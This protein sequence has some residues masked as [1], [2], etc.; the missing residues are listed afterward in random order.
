MYGIRIGIPVLPPYFVTPLDGVKMHW[1]PESLNSRISGKQSVTEGKRNSQ[2]SELQGATDESLNSRL[3]ELQGV[4]DES[5]NS[6]LQELQG[7]ADESL[8][9]R[10]YELHSAVSGNATVRIKVS[11]GVEENAYLGLQ[12]DGKSIGLV[13]KEAAESFIL[14][15]WGDGKV[16]LRAK[17]NGLLLTTR[18]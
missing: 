16:T 10:I 12:S 8:N 15:D 18:M 3:Q 6:R 7:A 13:S 1:Q 14:T 9:S 11:T 17:S 4:T 2:S 5:R